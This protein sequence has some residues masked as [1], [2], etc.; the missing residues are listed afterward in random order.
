MTDALLVYG[1]FIGLGL[2][3]FLIAWRDSKRPRNYSAE[4]RTGRVGNP[5]LF[6]ERDKQGRGNGH[7]SGE[8]NALTRTDLYRLARLYHS[9]L[10]LPGAN[11]RAER[12]DEQH[13]GDYRF[14]A[15]SIT[16]EA[17]NRNAII[18]ARFGE[19]QGE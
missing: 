11:P 3:E 4:L 17:G 15:Y 16:P 8:W 19:K 1:I 10:V 5:I 14:H 7:I 9:R 6:A 13:D 12:S 2:A 18:C